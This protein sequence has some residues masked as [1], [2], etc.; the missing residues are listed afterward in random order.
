[1]A[2]EIKMP[3]LSQTTDEVKLLRWMVKDGDS[4]KKGDILC[5]VE[6]DKV[7]ME[8]E[9]F[10]D[11]MVLKL[12]WEPGQQVKTGSVIA[13]LGE[14][15][16]ITGP[17]PVS[18]EENP[19]KEES[20]EGE[21][22]KE[23]HKIPG[24]AS[25]K[26]KATKLVQRLADKN[27]IDLS[28]VK[29]T[30]P[31]GII[32]RKDL[33]D[34]INNKKGDGGSGKGGSEEYWSLTPNQQAVSANIY[35]S[36]TSI[37]HYY[38]KTEVMAD[39]LLETRNADENVKKI[40]MYSYFIYYC[41]K[42]LE[43]FP[44]LNGYFKDNKIYKNSRINIG[45]AVAADDELYVPVLKDAN[46]KQLREIDREVKQ[47]A[48]R[49]QNKKLEPEDISGGTYTITNLGIYPI[50]EFYGVINYPQAV[51]LAIGKIGK[52]LKVADD[53]TMAIRN[54]F[55]ITGSFDHRIAN[56]AQAASFLTEIKRLLEEVGDSEL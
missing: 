21:D 28:E 8:V 4:V 16:E 41:A 36:K 15:G 11:G 2:V 46:K 55:N 10:A 9:S 53:N 37:P 29:G 1:M 6:T 43:K 31:R 32:T 17:P 42:A 35:K 54:V 56:G 39:N 49:A 22:K 25:S 12:N 13:I 50:D 24:E 23:D 51:L 26:V 7:N 19:E 47:L 45:F 27:N 38:L 40:S 5:E 52:I 34:H 14:K 30:G 48:A 44:R 33:E 18:K 3:N 20:P